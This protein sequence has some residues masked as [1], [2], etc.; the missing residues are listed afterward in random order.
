[1]IFDDFDNDEMLCQNAAKPNK[2]SFKSFN[3]ETSLDNELKNVKEG[4]D[5]ETAK[6]LFEVFQIQ[7]NER[8]FHI[9]NIPKPV[10]KPESIENLSK[11]ENEPFELR[12]KECLE[13]NLSG[14]LS[15]ELSQQC[16]AT[17]AKQNLQ[18]MQEETFSS[19]S[20]SSNTI[21]NLGKREGQQLEPKF[22]FKDH[23]SIGSLG[24]RRR[25]ISNFFHTNSRNRTLRKK[26][27]RVQGVSHN[28]PIYS[29]NDLVFDNSQNGQ[30]APKCFS[31]NSLFKDLVGNNED[32][33]INSLMSMDNIEERQKRKMSISESLCVICQRQFVLKD[34]VARIK[35][36]SHTFHKPCLEDWL[37]KAKASN[38]DCTCPQCFLTL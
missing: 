23:K 10:L 36:C 3:F 37:A 12:I 33:S 15:L 6:S 34:F 22:S 14:K 21:S 24:V 35:A 4:G 11:I 19:Q 30:L 32:N 7:L 26:Q 29:S 31:Q 17:Q 27:R 9:P 8:F 20:N 2:Q 16:S 18:A 5:S 1:M 38:Q 28:A 13:A 25:N